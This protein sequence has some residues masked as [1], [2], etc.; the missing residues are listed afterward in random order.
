[1]TDSPS[2]NSRFDAHPFEGPEDAT[3]DAICP[4][5]QYPRASILH[6]PSRIKATMAIVRRPQKREAEAS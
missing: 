5:C 1:M 2:T 6:H 3:K 4:F